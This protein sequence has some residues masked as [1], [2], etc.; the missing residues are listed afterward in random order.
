M[1]SLIVNS[2]DANDDKYSSSADDNEKRFSHDPRIEIMLKSLPRLDEIFEIHN[3]IGSGTFSSVYLSTLKSENDL[4]FA[5]RQKFAIKY[6]LPTSHP[7]RIERELMCLQKAGGC[8]NVVKLHFCMRNLDSVVFVM[9]YLEHDDFTNYL[10]DMGPAETQLYLRNLLIALCRVHTFNIIHRDVKPDNF[11]YDRKNKEFLLVDMGLAHHVDDKMSSM[12]K[13]IPLTPTIDHKRKRASDCENDHKGEASPAQVRKKVA[14]DTNKTITTPKTLDKFL[15]KSPLKPS[16][17]LNSNS[18][19]QNR[20]N[21]LVSN[22]RRTMLRL[23]LRSNLMDSEQ[24][25]AFTFTSPLPKRNSVSNLFDTKSNTQVSSPIPEKLQNEKNNIANSLSSK[26]IEKVS[27]NVEAS[28]KVKYNTNARLRDSR[29]SLLALKSSIQNNNK[30]KIKAE[31]MCECLGK[32]CVCLICRSRKPIPANRNGTRGFRPPE[33][34]LKYTDQTTAVDIW[35]V[36]IILLCILSRC[37]P[38]F[39]APDDLT[40]LAEQI[41]LFGTTKIKNL[42]TL[43]KRSI[44]MDCPHLKE[45]NLREVCTILRQRDC[46]NKSYLKF[47]KRSAE[48]F[49]DSTYDLL[50]KLLDVNPFTRITAAEALNHKFFSENLAC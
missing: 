50:S 1:S 19:T 30:N 31:K 22:D 44:T 23:G 38:F 40:A 43:L 28:S 15:I 48:D 12:P 25:K 27:T 26:N 11:L 14:L 6:L 29:K 49:P 42:A 36:G 18:L 35:A 24:N 32:S 2:Q 13:L 45:S 41:T 9:P 47:K 20:R 21:S 39:D 10:L 7:K 46:F 33:V 3:C 16:N 5:E 34:L 37:Y 8:D 4:A 17:N